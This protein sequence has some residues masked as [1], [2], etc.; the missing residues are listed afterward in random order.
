MKHLRYGLLL[1]VLG[2]NVSSSFAQQEAWQKENWLIPQPKQNQ[3]LIGGSAADQ[4]D[5]GTELKPEGNGWRIVYLL[6]GGPG[7]KA[8]LALGDF[9][10]AIDGVPISQMAEATAS[11]RIRST[12]HPGDRGIFRYQRGGKEF[13]TAVTFEAVRKLY[14]NVAL[15]PPSVLQPIGGTES[16]ISAAVEAES[17]YAQLR[18]EVR[19]N[20]STDW[21]VNEAQFFM[22]DG[23][24]QSLLRPNLSEIKY[25]FDS[26]VATYWHGEQYPIPPPP[27]PSVRYR[28]STDTSGNYSVSQ[29]GSGW[30]NITGQSESTM[31]VMAEPD[32]G[33]WAYWIQR[34][35]YSIGALNY[36]KQA[37]QYNEA[38]YKL[39]EG[40]KAFWDQNYFRSRLPIA[41]K[42]NRSGRL[43]YWAGVQG[44]IVLPLKVVMVV[45][46]P[47]TMKTETVSLEFH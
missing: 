7:E 21:S 22:L 26:I 44:K 17:E 23:N 41:P 39:A 9:V 24:G 18:I 19:N 20:T 5:A 3:M 35:S 16:W 11:G 40:E 34:F 1:A 15:I 43:L 46:N 10:V 47:E 25:I 14:P 28:I 6:P 30:F 13:E 37:R 31:T 45:T 27:P 33:N 12:L 36:L 2:L 4:A 8:G 42:H 29:T 38:L 32:S